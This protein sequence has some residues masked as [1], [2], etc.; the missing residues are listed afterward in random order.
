VYFVIFDAAIII[1]NMIKDSR[2]YNLFFDFIKAYS[3][4]GFTGIDRDD[5]LIL[6]LEEM[7]NENRQYLAVFDMLRMK[8][9]FVSQGCLKFLGVTPEDLTSYHFKEA[10][11]PDD[12]KRSELGL[13]KLFKS[14]HELFV[15]K[16]GEVL[17][18]SNFRMRIPEGN[19]ID[20]LIQCYLFYSIAPTET[21]YMTHI[22]TDISWSNKLKHGFHYY[23]GNDL[24][25]F[26]YPDDELLMTG[27]IFSERE[28]EIIKLVHQ[29]LDSEHIAE[30]LF[31]SKHTVNTHRKNILDK[32]GKASIAELIYDMHEMGLL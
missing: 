11:H 21:V 1:L 28:F 32:T 27:N 13:V 2:R 25:K 16:K 29:G 5:P 15:A 19:Y 14:A 9:L 31:L 22:N 12:L 30:K 4:K 23:L 7:M 6:S 8:T 24:S 10:T 26:R 3:Q 20:Q 17:I 18:S